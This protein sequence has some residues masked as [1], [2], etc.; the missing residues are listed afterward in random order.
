M[1][2]QYS[3][4]LRPIRPRSLVTPRRVVGCT[5]L[6]AAGDARASEWLGWMPLWV[7]GMPLAAWWALHRF[8]LPRWV[9]GRSN[10][11]GYRGGGGVVQARRR[12]Q[13]VVGWRVAAA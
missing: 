12:S 4:Q 5:L 3:S 1:P 13:S 11:L 6:F 8:R 7:L 9:K 10:D 2:P